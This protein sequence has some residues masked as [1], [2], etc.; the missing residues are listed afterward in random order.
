MHTKAR[1]K[2]FV[3]GASGYIG[4]SVARALLEA[5]HGVRG[6]TRTAESARG[7]AA[8]GIEPVIGSLDD[9]ALLA[10]EAGA[11]DA[12]IH[13]A[14]ADHAL[15]VDALLAALAGSGKPLLHT[16]GSSVV[17][18]DARGNTLSGRIFDDEHPLT[19]APGKQARHNIDR[20][21]LAAAQ[22]GIRSCVICP[23]LVYGV[24]R[25]LKPHSVQIP[26]L[27]EQAARMGRVPVVGEG[28]NV[29][30]NVHL[31][32]LV[33]LYQRVLERGAAG[34]FYFAENGE[35]SFAQIAQAIAQRMGLPGTV[36]VPADVAAERWGAP[37]AL[38]SLAS[39]SRVRAVR[40]RR[41][42]GWSPRHMGVLDWISREMPIPS[43]CST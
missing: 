24:G 40:A 33:D 9:G 7:L 38:F 18:D 15:S 11:A 41:E 26:F 19:V 28:R 8:F 32:A 2:L 3:T 43:P 22:Q 25:G 29:W 35:A 23:S 17:G 31:D 42:L 30:S 5:G 12:V 34:A 37:R 39:N 14:N 6:L 20:R 13:T 10:C 21:V 36:S 4:G 27:V 16:S 1:M